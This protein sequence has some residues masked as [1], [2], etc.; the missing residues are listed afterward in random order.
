MQDGALIHSRRLAAFGFARD[1]FGDAEYP[2]LG[3][4]RAF[5]PG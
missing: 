5:D 4:P 3:T 2:M 1:T